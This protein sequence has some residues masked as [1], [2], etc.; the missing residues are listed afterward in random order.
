MNVLD[1]E[2][3]D[4]KNLFYLSIADGSAFEIEVKSRKTENF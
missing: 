2:A 3:D 1:V 4:K